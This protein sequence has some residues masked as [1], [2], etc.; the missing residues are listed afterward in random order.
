MG[1]LNSHDIPGL[2]TW[3]L[4]PDDI[5]HNPLQDR[6]AAQHLTR[7]PTGL[8]FIQ[9]PSSDYQDGITYPYFYIEAEPNETTNTWECRTWWT[10]HLRHASSTDYLLPLAV[11]AASVPPQHQ[12][13]ITPINDPSDIQWRAIW[14]IHNTST[15]PP[16]SPIF[17]TLWQ[18]YEYARTCRRLH[19]A[20]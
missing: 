6:W 14:D 18:F 7:T 1:T 15:M 5:L 13:T 3:T 9:L 4:N 10:Y 11:Q 8:T 20:S 12:G 17:M 2:Y 19:P 16:I